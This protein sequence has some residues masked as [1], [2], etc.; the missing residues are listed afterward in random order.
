MENL[1]FRKLKSER[2][3]E[4]LEIGINAAGLSKDESLKALKDLSI[5]EATQYHLAIETNW[6]HTI[7]LALEMATRI[8]R[9]ENGLAA[10]L[11]IECTK[12]G[13]Q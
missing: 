3:R 13:I 6:S 5:K 11:M 7:L 10:I 4:A 2:A 9:E 8:E 1:L 12:T